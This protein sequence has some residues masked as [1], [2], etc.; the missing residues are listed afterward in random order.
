MTQK[1]SIRFWGDRQVRAVWDEQH[2]KWW[3]SA[4]D[5][6]RGFMGSYIINFCN[7]APQSDEIDDRETFMKGIARIKKLMVFRTP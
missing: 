1:K 4:V 3:F 5:I 2:S 6:A 7:G